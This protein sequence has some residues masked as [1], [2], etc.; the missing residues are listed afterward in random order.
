MGQPEPPTLADWPIWPEGL[1]HGV[2]GSAWRK[3]P[4]RQ[5]RSELSC[6]PRR[7]AARPRRPVPRG[8]RRLAA[9]GRRRWL[10]HQGERG[11]GQG[12]VDQALPPVRPGRAGRGRRRGC[13]RQRL[14]I[15]LLVLQ[16]GRSVRSATE[17]AIPMPSPG[18]R[19]RCWLF[20]RRSVHPEGAAV[21]PGALW[22]RLRLS[23]Q[24]R[25]TR[26]TATIWYFYPPLQ[27]Y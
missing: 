19:G 2:W 10:R 7:R 3:L 23:S 20:G 26:L 16:H 5:P 4:G 21:P 14:R 12:C 1:G 27:L 8:G 15:W 25:P 11:D 22:C 13:E 6:F 24:P 9:H 17:P 18:G